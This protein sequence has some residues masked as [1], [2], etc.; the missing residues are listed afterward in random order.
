MVILVAMIT[1]NMR[2]RMRTERW[3]RFRNGV[4]RSREDDDVGLG[5]A[6]VLCVSGSLLLEE[7]V[8]IGRS[9]F[10]FEE[11]R[12]EENNECVERMWDHPRCGD[13]TSSRLE[14]ACER[15]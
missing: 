8:E 14:C 2:N 1:R 3:N 11:R 4:D 5:G 6:G 10:D 7:L 15:K 9:R 13:A 12:S